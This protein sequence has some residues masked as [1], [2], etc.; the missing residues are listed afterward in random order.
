MP[1][2]VDEDIKQA[3][4]YGSHRG[5]QEDVNRPFNYQFHDDGVKFRLDKRFDTKPKRQI[6]RYPGEKMETTYSFVRIP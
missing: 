5:H 6:R 4:E 3:E 2:D 1:G